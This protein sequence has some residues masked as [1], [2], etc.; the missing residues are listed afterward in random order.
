MVSRERRASIQF[1][2]EANGTGSSVARRAT[3]TGKVN[4]MW[5]PLTPVQF[6]QR[7]Q[8]WLQG[9]L[10][11]DAFPMLNADQREFILTGMMPGDFED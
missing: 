10:I 4:T 7:R 2:V 8:F 9:E 11:Q 3:F 1:A 6:E 5:L